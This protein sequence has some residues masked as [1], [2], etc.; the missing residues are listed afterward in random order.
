ML[1][2]RDGLKVVGHQG[3]GGVTGSLDALVDAL[4]GVRVPSDFE[5]G[6]SVID[7]R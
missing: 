4:Q 6:A 5:E 2:D 3:A 7:W 1:N